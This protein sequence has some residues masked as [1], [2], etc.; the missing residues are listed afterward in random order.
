M[1]DEKLTLRV[2]I[3]KGFIMASH[4]SATRQA[5]GSKVF[6]FGRVTDAGGD[7][8]GQVNRRPGWVRPCDARGRVELSVN[9]ISLN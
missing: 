7:A 1:R 8:G 6:V 5:D 9:F 3:A 4:G 2:C